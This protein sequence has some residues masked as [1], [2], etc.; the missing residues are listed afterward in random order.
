MISVKNL[1]RANHAQK[2]A[3][4]SFKR[5]IFGW[6]NV[7]E[8]MNRLF[9][10]ILKN[11]GRNGQK[12]TQKNLKSSKIAVFCLLVNER[13][14]KLTAILAIESFLLGG[15]ED[16]NRTSIARYKWP[17]TKLQLAKITDFGKCR[18]AKRPAPRSFLKIQSPK[19][20]H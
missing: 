8:E 7:P 14:Q 19:S 20:L 11:C 12:T 16:N 1:F 2:K 3:Q 13:Q 5:K 6:T 9:S 15:K 10:V 17:P 18:L 4:K